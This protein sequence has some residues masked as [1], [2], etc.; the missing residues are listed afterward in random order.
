MS[1]KP[2]PVVATLQ[3]MNGDVIS[4]FVKESK[5]PI[6]MKTCTP[7][8]CTAVRNHLSMP[9]DC[10]DCSQC[11]CQIHFEHDQDGKEQDGKKQKLYPLKENKLFVLVQSEQCHSCSRVVYPD[12]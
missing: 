12:Y 2:Q 7:V 9:S 10:S 5:S 6:S 3:F 4:V 1:K 11:L 8:L